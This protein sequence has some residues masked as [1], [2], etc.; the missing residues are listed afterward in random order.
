VTVLQLPWAGVGDVRK[1]DILLVRVPA[2]RVT[3]PSSRRRPA[4]LAHDD[5]EA[6]A[7]LRALLQPESEGLL[8]P[9]VA[10]VPRG[11]VQA[12][13][14][15]AMQRIRRHPA[16][17]CEPTAR[18]T[19]RH[20]PAPL[21]VNDLVSDGHP[22][23]DAMF[24]FATAVLPH[25]TTR[26]MHHG[27]RLVAAEHLDVKASLERHWAKVEAEQRREAKERA[28]AAAAALR[29]AEERRRLDEGA[30][31][32]AAGAERARVAAEAA[33]AAAAAAAERAAE[34][35]RAQ[36]AARAEAALAEQ[37]RAQRRRR[38]EAARQDAASRRMASLT[39]LPSLRAA[40]QFANVEYRQAT[41]LQAAAL[42]K[43][44]E[45][46]PAK[47]LDCREYAYLA[48]TWA[49]QRSDAPM[50]RIAAW[51]ATQYATQRRFVAAAEEK[52]AALA[53]RCESGEF[54]S[55]AACT[56]AADQAARRAGPR[57]LGP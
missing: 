15:L 13:M 24:G 26:R 57:L 9:Q 1:Y 23:R 11:Q 3:T 28:D 14:L 25:R 20:A 52:A 44:D 19:C 38:C 4:A 48:P 18:T 41:A 36:A 21:D 54:G 6:R 40:L 37:E 46:D 32:A 27:Y 17:T 55:I 8:C 30:A 29:A 50:V 33:Q 56:C 45:L 49:A 22:L 47:T 12:A 2:D 43:L 34:Q 35:R 16:C 39:K 42:A 51:V 5:D 53:L 7:L 31:A 10:G